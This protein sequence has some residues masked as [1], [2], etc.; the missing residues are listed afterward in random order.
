MAVTIRDVALHAGVGR[1]TVSRVLNGSPR[2]DSATRARV[3]DAI[4]TLDY[5]PSR[6]ARRLSI[7]K[8]LT[9]GVVVPFM[10]RPSVVERL[11]GVE[12]ALSRSA[13]DMIVFNVETADRRDAILRELPRADRVDGLI[14]ISLS[15]RAAEVERIRAS[16]VPT[17]LIDAHHR[18]INRIVADDVAGGR[19]A[20]EHLIGLGHRRIGFV[21][22]RPRNAFSFFS[23]RLRFSGLRQAL[24]REGLTLPREW[25]AVGD[26]GR[27]VARDAAARILSSRPR[28]TAIACASDT[29]ALGVLEAARALG[30]RVPEEVSV[31]GYD[32]IEVAGHLHLTTIRQALLESGIRGA[33]LVVEL[34][35]TAHRAAAGSGNGSGAPPDSDR[36]RREEVPIELVVRATTGPPP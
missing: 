21:G 15:P 17:I 6:T 35:E 28:P 31:V 2:V 12:F 27:T 23:S 4:A 29:Q 34:M 19:M 32:D 10:T 7:G 36:P 16:G 11:R 14:I 20:A 8:T 1:G 33:Q 24:V 22:D 26:H 3:L 9:V 13:Y 25:V 30:L 5:A 18:A